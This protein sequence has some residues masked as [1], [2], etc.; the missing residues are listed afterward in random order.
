MTY[1]YCKIPLMYI[2]PQQLVEK[3][4]RIVSIFEPKLRKK[5]YCLD[6]KIAF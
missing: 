6:S 3:F 1:S 2:F 5:A 4:I